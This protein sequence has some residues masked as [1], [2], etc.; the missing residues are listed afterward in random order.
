MSAEI[1]QNA[2]GSINVSLTLMPGASMF[3]SEMN[4][5]AA[6]NEAGTVVTGECLR[7]F[8]TDGGK[9]QVAG[10]KLTSCGM[11]PKNYQTPYGVTRIERHIY[12]S[13]AGGA[14]YCPLEYGAR[15][16]RTTTPTAR[17]TCGRGSKPGTAEP[18]PGRSSTSGPPVNTSRHARPPCARRSPGARRG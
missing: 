15:I 6:L 1:Q 12:Q 16:M 11:R 17:T 18:A 3:G 5:Q 14:T 10:R 7:R 9:L 8:D 2:D 13:R 4:I